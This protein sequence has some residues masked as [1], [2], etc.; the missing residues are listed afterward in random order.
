[1]LELDFILSRKA[2]MLA[3]SA[4]LAISSGPMWAE[5]PNA[6]YDFDPQDAFCSRQ[7]MHLVSRE[8]VR[9]WLDYVAGLR[10]GRSTPPDPETC[11]SNTVRQVFAAVMNPHTAAAERVAMVRYFASAAMDGDNVA[12][13]TDET[14]D[15]RYL[16]DVMAAS[17]LWLVC[18][19]VDGSNASCMSES[20]AVLPSDFLSSSP[21]FCDF[22]D[23]PSLELI[24]NSHA[25]EIQDLPG[26]C[27]AVT[28]PNARAEKWLR[29]FE[30]A[31][32][33]E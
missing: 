16:N 15:F 24:E 7:T 2:I 14:G 5:T 18:P 27:S 1:M 8:E 17:L 6:A 31:M 33:T 11:A 30:N 12:R 26:V 3:V 29:T 19:A 21:V 28:S 20:L 32:R 23:S 4:A 10:T 9:P 22:S 25:N 13:M